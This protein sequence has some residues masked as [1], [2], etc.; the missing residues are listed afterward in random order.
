MLTVLL[1][2]DAKYGKVK[3]YVKKVI[4][5]KT[6]KQSNIEQPQQLPGCF[7]DVDRRAQPKP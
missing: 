1:G 4:V 5:E 6:D 7:E 2:L 3:E